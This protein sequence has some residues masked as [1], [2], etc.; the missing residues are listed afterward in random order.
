MSEQPLLLERVRQTRFHVDNAGRPTGPG[1]SNSAGKGTTG[2]LPG[3]AGRWSTPASQSEKVRA[4]S[5]PPE[6]SSSAACARSRRRGPWTGFG[7]VSPRVSGGGGS[8]SCESRKGRTGPPRIRRW[9]AGP[10]FRLA[11]EYVRPNF[12]ATPQS[13]GALRYARMG[14]KGIRPRD[15][16]D[17]QTLCRRRLLSR[18]DRAEQGHNQPRPRTG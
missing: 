13:H 16:T 7:R 5:S 6:R 18:R 14:D 3:V 9:K 2:C 15:R 1:S 10:V 12:A 8:D 17:Q 4:G 11:R